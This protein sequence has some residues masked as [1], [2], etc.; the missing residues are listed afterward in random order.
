MTESGNRTFANL[1]LRQTWQVLDRWSV[2]AGLDRT[3]TLKGPDAALLN[4]DAPPA[5][6]TLDDDF[7]ALS[8]GSTYR[9]DKWSWTTRVETRVGDQENK[10]GVFSGLYR[11][12]NEGL[13][14]SLRLELNDANPEVG[15]HATAGNVRV[16]LAYRPLA[17]RWLLLDRLDLSFDNE[18]GGSFVFRN[19]K[20]VNN[21]ALNY[22]WNRRL[23]I[24]LLYGSRYQGETI[25]GEGF[26]GYTDLTAIE[27]R[28]DLGERWDLSGGLR[29][30]HSYDSDLYEPS[31]GISL[32]YRLA[33][34]LWVSAG[35]NFTGFRD[36]DFSGAQYS[37]KGPFLRFRYK[38]DQETVRGFLER[39]GR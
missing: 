19:R 21:L 23:Q 24:S 4:P 3:Q 16:G 32:G 13:G 28:R 8:F 34:N 10:W 36:D 26:G 5:S 22:R 11:E 14:Y 6:G 7:T 15:S 37:A 25:E 20:I 27:F 17:S 31:Y 9:A 18:R 29:M 2:D 35:Y 12:V 30:R 39:E 38:F 1:G 33:R